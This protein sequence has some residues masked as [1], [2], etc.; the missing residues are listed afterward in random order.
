M[1]RI[2]RS[3]RGF[4]TRGRPRITSLSEVVPFAAFGYMFLWP[5][6][7]RLWIGD[8]FAHVETEFTTTE[9]WATFPGW[10]VGG[11]T[12]LVCGFAAVYF[13]GAKGFCTYACPY[14]AIEKMRAVRKE[15][16]YCARCY[17]A[18]P[19]NTKAGAAI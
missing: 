18:C 9:F 1:R 13:L 15:C 16:L 11:L 17:A 12:F 6:A 8:S 2:S 7:Y 3:G 19:R 14:G 10:I 4:A 5:V